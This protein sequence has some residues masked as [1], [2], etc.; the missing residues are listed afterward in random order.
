MT[1]SY[2]TVGSGDHHVLAVHGWFGSAH[3]WGALPEYVDVDDFTY[4]PLPYAQR[5]GGSAELPISPRMRES[6]GS[7]SSVHDQPPSWL[8]CVRRFP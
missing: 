5:H 2:A 6:A 4:R 8:I 3:G 7:G 1:A